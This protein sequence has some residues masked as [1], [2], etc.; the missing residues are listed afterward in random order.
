MREERKSVPFKEGSDDE[1]NA[2][3]RNRPEQVQQSRVVD[4][5]WRVGEFVPAAVLGHP[6]ALGPEPVGEGR[7]RTRVRL[8][9]HCGWDGAAVAVAGWG[10]VW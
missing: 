7:E 1:Q 10:W 3:E 6:E 2:G 5:G 8:R 4:A 9:H